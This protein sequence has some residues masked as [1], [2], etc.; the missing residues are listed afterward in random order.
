MVYDTMVA[1]VYRD[2]KTTLTINRM[3]PYTSYISVPSMTSRCRSSAQGGSP[4][5]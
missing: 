5:S 1:T 2:R 4:R 3:T